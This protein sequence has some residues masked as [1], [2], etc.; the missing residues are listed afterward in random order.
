MGRCG[1]ARQDTPAM[2]TRPA[3][4]AWAATAAAGLQAAG[5]GRRARWQPAAR[6]AG[7]GMAAGRP[8][9]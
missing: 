1:A 4:P 8:G 9:K 5:I 3:G 7:R 6:P 2:V